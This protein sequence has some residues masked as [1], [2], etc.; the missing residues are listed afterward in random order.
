MPPAA[1]RSPLKM[2]KERLEE[3]ANFHLNKVILAGR[4]TADP[5]LKQT[6][7][8]VSFCSFSLAVNRRFKEE[9]KEGTDFLPIVAWRA[10]AEFVC[11]F[12]KKGSSLCAVGTLRTKTWTDKEGKKRSSLEI[13]AEELHFVDSKGESASGVTVS[14]PASDD[15]GQASFDGEAEISLSEDEGQLPF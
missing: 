5:E 11:R 9:G 6:A 3:M 4:L 7:G 13:V 1:V 15:G 12:F 8:G 10:N 2:R 14:P